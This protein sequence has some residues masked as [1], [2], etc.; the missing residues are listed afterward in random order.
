M[1]TLEER[2]RHELERLSPPG[3]PAGVVDRVLRGAARRHARRSVGIVLLTLSVIA[4]SGGGFVALSRVFGGSE[5]PSRNTPAAA[6]NGV[7]ALSLHSEPLMPAN[8]RIALLDPAGEG[9]RFL[10]GGDRVATTP[11]WSPDGSQLVFWRAGREEQNGLWIMQADGSQA[12]LLFETT[13]SIWAIRWSPDGS[14][15]AFV[16]VVVPEGPATE[17]DFSDDLYVM[18]ADGTE[19]TPLITD[20]HV[21]DFDWSP[22]GTRLV[23]ERLFAIG[24]DRLGSDLAIVG[25]DAG[26]EQPLTTDGVSQDPTWSPDGS[27]IVYVGSATGNVRDRDLFA[28]APDGSGLVQLT[29]DEG[30]E[31]DPV[32]SPDGS[33]VAYTRFPQG[34]GSA[35]ELVVMES[36][37]TAPRVLATKET[38]KGCPVALAWQPILAGEEVSP[39]PSP[40][41]SPSESPASEAAQDIGLGFPV[42]DVTSVSGT[43]AHGLEG[44][45]YVATKAPD[46]GGCPPGEEA[47]FEVLALDLDGDQRAEVSHGPLECIVGCSAL[48]APDINRDGIAEIAVGTGRADGESAMLFRVE[49]SDGGLIIDQIE[50]APPADPEH[51]FAPGR[52]LFVISGGGLSSSGGAYCLDREDAAERLFVIWQAMLR[53]PETNAW[54]VTSGAFALDDGELVLDRVETYRVPEDEPELPRRIDSDLCGAPVV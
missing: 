27:S 49:V 42:C 45:A 13:A 47:P 30:T 2:L 22:D 43:F 4:G 17:L 46:T 23:I 18:N 48:A 12:R 31:E 3:D 37:G 52:V 1:E 8:Q 25:A 6:A 53:D 20:G 44:T 32:F 38:L 14:R 36:D 28:I 54:D 33:F 9:L 11:A 51:G 15:I 34:D 21:T 7:I 41:P 29:D 24:E 35:C 39:Q 40:S 5:E 50:I 26:R 16:N 10:T 19:V